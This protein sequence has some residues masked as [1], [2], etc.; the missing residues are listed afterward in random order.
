MQSENI[1]ICL[2][3]SDSFPSFA[4]QIIMH[5]SSILRCIP[6]VPIRANKLRAEYVMHLCSNNSETKMCERPSLLFAI[7]NTVEDRR[8]TQSRSNVN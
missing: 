8:Q 4:E 1:I 7:A 6:H 2:K 3:Y 5:A